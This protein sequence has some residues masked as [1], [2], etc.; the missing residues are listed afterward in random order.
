MC[1]CDY[2]ETGEPGGGEEQEDH[3]AG[4][5]DSGVGASQREQVVAGKRV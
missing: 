3:A 5:E 4:G 1:R 2:L